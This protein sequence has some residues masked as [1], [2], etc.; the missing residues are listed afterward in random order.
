LI[1]SLSVC[2]ELSELQGEE[3][4]RKRAGGGENQKKRGLQ[5]KRNRANAG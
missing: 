1:L 3:G 2:V 5:Y 4:E